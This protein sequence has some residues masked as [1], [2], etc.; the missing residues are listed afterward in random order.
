MILQGLNRG[1]CPRKHLTAW[2]FASSDDVQVPVE[3]Y[4]ALSVPVYQRH[5]S[6]CR[7]W[8]QGQLV[9]LNIFQGEMQRMHIGPHSG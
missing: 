3:V 8:S 6:A 1:F 4:H 2:T 5:R 9:D 7:G